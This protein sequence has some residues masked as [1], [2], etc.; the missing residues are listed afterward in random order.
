MNRFRHARFH[1]FDGMRTLLTEFYECI[2]Q[3]TPPPIPYDEILR[4]SA[5]MDRIFEQVYPEMHS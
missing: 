2:E 4:V 3:N 5:M 1:F